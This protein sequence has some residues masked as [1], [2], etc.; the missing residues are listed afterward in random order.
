MMAGIAIISLL[1]ISGLQAMVMACA[2]F[3]MPISMTKVRRTFGTS[4]ARS[5]TKSR[6]SAQ[7]KIKERFGASF[8]V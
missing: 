6:G 3:C 7:F 4:A 1:K 8:F 5:T 2:A